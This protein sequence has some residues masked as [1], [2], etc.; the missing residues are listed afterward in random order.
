MPR[1]A[2]SSED[3]LRKQARMFRE[4]TPQGR[5][6]AMQE[7]SLFVVGLADSDVRRRH[8]EWSDSRI[9][10]EASRRW[11]TPGDHARLVSLTRS[12]SP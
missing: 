11:L 4:M 8:P 2:D 1:I 7:M 12:A 10:L 9:R 3:I 5:L 6:E